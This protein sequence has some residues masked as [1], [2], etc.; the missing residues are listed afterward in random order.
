MEVGVISVRY[1]KALFSFAKE[2]GVADRVFV[3]ISSLEKALMAEPR[4]RIAL[5]S[6]VLS[7][8][9]KHELARTAA[10]NGKQ[11]SDESDRFLH[12]VLK[13]RR[14]G[15][16]LFICL[17]YQ[18]LY[19]KE[20]NIRVGKLTLA[21]PIDRETAHKLIKIAE[22]KLEST[23]DLRVNVDPKIKGGFI[24]EVDGNRLDASVATQLR[25]VKQ[26]FIA[27]NRR[28]V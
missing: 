21:T 14:E 3:E 4:L 19:R 24:F 1:A 20:N 5:Q 15:D 13:N 18:D 22:H 8:Q 17:M 16:L 26:Q 27:I 23:L 7:L 12:L 9:K 2:R 11:L 6:P 25:R 28:I 10:S